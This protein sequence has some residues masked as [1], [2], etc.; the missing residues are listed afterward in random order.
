MAP[1][2]LGRFEKSVVIFDSIQDRCSTAFGRRWTHQNRRL[3]SSI[4]PHNGHEGCST[5]NITRKSRTLHLT[6]MWLFITHNR[7]ISLRGR[8]RNDKHHWI[9][10]LISN[11]LRPT[12]LVSLLINE[13]MHSWSSSMNDCKESRWQTAH[14]VKIQWKSPICNGAIP[15]KR[16]LGAKTPPGVRP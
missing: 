16:L 15:P 3:S 5:R 7:Q 8:S 14:A 11:K 12:T 6:V 13:N 4:H 2:G 1:L 10:Q 9:H